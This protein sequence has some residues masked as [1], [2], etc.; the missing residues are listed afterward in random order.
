L[1]LLKT[2]VSEKI[3]AAIASP[4]EAGAPLQE[5]LIQ[6]PIGGTVR[7]DQLETIVIKDL[8]HCL[9][10]ARSGQFGFSPVLKNVLLRLET[11]KS[12][13]GE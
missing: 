8:E 13:K 11:I 12:T 6:D 4:P 2:V 1:K 7:P 3:G 5:N 10:L 9:D